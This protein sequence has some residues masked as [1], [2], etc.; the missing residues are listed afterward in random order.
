MVR[1]LQLPALTLLANPVMLPVPAAIRAMDVFPAV[2]IR[3]LMQA[4]SVCVAAALN[5]KEGA[6]S[7]QAVAVMAMAVAVTMVA[8]MMVA[9]VP[10]VVVPVVVVPVVAVP[11]QVQ[12]LATIPDSAA[13]PGLVVET[14]VVPPG[15]A[16]LPYRGDYRALQGVSVIFKAARDLHSS[17]PHPLLLF[18]GR[19]FGFDEFVCETALV[20]P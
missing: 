18:P 8:A 12:C 6:V 17:S 15:R 16:I 1:V 2:P 5:D 11:A 20:E 13:M 19:P 14:S 3:F 9:V 4:V 10:V 7:F